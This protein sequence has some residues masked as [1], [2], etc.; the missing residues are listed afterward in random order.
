MKRGRRKGARLAQ[1]SCGKRF[2]VYPI[3]DGSKT[4]RGCRMPYAPAE[5]DRIYAGAFLWGA[6]L[7]TTEVA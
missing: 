4:C 6:V 1:C 3:N 5:L 7:V 2:V